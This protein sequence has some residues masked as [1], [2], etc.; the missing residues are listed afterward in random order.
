MNLIMNLIIKS[1][2]KYKVEYRP[3][4]FFT[5]DINLSSFIASGENTPSSCCLICMNAIEPGDKLHRTNC[6]HYYHYQCLYDNIKKL[7]NNKDYYLCP[8]C[9]MH[10]SIRYQ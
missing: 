7:Y 5:T 6:G 9:K 2:K 10:N 4:K 3:F 1:Y 8:L